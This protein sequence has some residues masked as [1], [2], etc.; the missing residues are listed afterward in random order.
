M[1]QSLKIELPPSLLINK[2]RFFRKSQIEHLKRVLIAKAVGAAEPP[3][4]E[5]E[6]E[7][8]VPAPQVA[9]EFGLSK[10][11]FWRRLKDAELASR[12]SHQGAI[13]A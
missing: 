9:R 10:R 4:V 1:Y 2:R 6:S 11:T 3:Y 5:P 8:F 7:S 12:N 13:A